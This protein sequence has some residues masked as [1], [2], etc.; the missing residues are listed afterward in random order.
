MKE[1]IIK[2]LAREGILLDSAVV[3]ILIKNSHKISYLKEVLGKGFWTL[4]KV[5]NILSSCND[6]KNNEKSIKILRNVDKLEVECSPESFRAL[7]LNRYKVISSILRRRPSL[8]GCTTISHIKKI[9][10]EV[11]VV[12]IVK[13]IE[14][15]RIILEDE[16][17]HIE[18]RVSKKSDE[19]V[20]L[21]DEVIGVR[22][23][24]KGDIIYLDELIY[25]EI[26]FAV[27]SPANRGKI[28]AIS[29][30]HVGS[31]MFEE[32]RFLKFIDYIKEEREIDYIC[33]AGDLVDGVGVYPDQEEELEYL[34][35][36]EQYQVLASYLKEIPSHVKIFLIPG[37]HDAVICM[38]PQPPLSDEIRKL[39]PDNVYFLSNPSYIE[40]DGII[41]LIYHG[42]SLNDVI[43]RVPNASYEYIEPALV[44]LLRVRH[45]LPMYGGKV[46]MVP[47]KYD[48][49]IIDP[50][51]HIFITG[52]VHSYY[53]GKYKN[54]IIINASTW[55]SMTKYQK[56]LNFNPIVGKVCVVNLSNMEVKTLEF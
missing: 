46:S 34:D 52:H 21:E 35:V 11:V 48:Y 32:E 16:T 50:T 47:T 30:I 9:S 29:D 4:E 44:H 43:E 2:E 8:R 22:G 18:V 19:D 53:V 49:L 39:F 1:N 7:F 36:Y 33:V 40:I 10:G 45:L 6:N 42:T 38:E 3:D 13:K 55:Q 31:N 56:M 51:P 23:F 26:D 17:G 14:N 37:N 24:K 27:F 25:P 12:G 41:I 20:V 54:T 5:Q 15:N 28:A